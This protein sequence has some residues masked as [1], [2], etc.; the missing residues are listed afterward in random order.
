MGEETGTRRSHEAKI[1]VKIRG[2]PLKKSHGRRVMET[3]GDSFLLLQTK[4][5]KRLWAGFVRPTRIRNRPRP[6][7]CFEYNFL[8]FCKSY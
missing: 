8:T 4:K 1:E 2:W 3:G 7:L 5:K 6:K